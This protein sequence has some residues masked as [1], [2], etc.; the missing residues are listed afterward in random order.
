MFIWQWGVRNYP[1]GIMVEI[2]PESRA[3]NALH[4]VRDTAGLHTA[5][6]FRSGGLILHRGLENVSKTENRKG[7]WSLWLVILRPASLKCFIWHRR[8]SRREEKNYPP[9]SSSSKNETSFCT[10]DSELALVKPWLS[11]TLF[12]ISV[13]YIQGDCRKLESALKGCS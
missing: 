9:F 2:V 7:K 11:D 5:L 13:L 4:L 8:A 6:Q 10:V 12:I 1:P 3:E